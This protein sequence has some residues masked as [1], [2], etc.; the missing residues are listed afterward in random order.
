ML[1][2][3]YNRTASLESKLG[4][5]LVSVD[6]DASVVQL[7]VLSAMNVSTSSWSSKAASSATALE[8][9]SVV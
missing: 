2:T 7:I 4:L 9:L 6:I 3:Q 5:P 8:R 1:A